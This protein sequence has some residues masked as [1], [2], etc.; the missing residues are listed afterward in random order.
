MCNASI[1]LATSSIF[2]IKENSYNGSHNNNTAVAFV[3]S[4]SSVVLNFEIQG[5]D[6]SEIWLADCAASNHITF[7]QEWMRNYRS[8]K[9]TLY[10]GTN[11]SVRVIGVR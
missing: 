11:Y 6:V 1:L 3:A 8:I 4:A 10:T 9:E 7:H 5:L 2:K